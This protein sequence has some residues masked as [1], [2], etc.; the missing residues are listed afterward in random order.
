MWQQV[1]N[2]LNNLRHDPEVALV[3][4]VPITIMEEFLKKK[5]ANSKLVLSMLRPLF[6]GVNTQGSVS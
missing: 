2:R 1:A 5:N 3:R 6:A 4:H